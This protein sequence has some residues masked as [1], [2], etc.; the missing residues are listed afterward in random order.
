VFLF[1]WDASE[2]T[3]QDINPLYANKHDPKILFGKGYIG[4]LDQSEQKKQYDK[5]NGH[6]IEKGEDFMTKPKE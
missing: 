4:G 1:D 6:G 3:S 5:T 2:D